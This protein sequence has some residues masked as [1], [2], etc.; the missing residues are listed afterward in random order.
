MNLFNC[1]TFKHFSI[2]PSLMVIRLATLLIC[3]LFLN[4]SLQAE[5]LIKAEGY[6]IHYNAFNTSML[7]PEV[8]NK[9]GIER[10][11][12]LG[13]VNISVLDES[14]KAVS[15]L[16]LGEAKNAISQLTTLEFKKI[17]EGKAIYFIATFNFADAETLNFDITVVPDGMTKRIKLN[18]SQQ[19]FKE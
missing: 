13:I 17:T 19:F 9:Y 16:L 4:S 1:S 18:F 15:A 10:S 7:D 2:H 8:V 11:T 6:S 12:T 5:Q 3:S 14:D